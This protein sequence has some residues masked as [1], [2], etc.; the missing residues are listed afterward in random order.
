MGNLQK[1]PGEPLTLINNPIFDWIASTA[2]TAIWVV[3]SI[4]F[5][6]FSAVMTNQCWE[7]LK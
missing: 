2:W 4:I 3:F 7:W 1:A 6:A 5:G